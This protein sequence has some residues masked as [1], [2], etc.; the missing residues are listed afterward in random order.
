[1]YRHTLNIMIFIVCYIMLGRGYIIAWTSRVYA[2]H[3]TLPLCEG[4]D[5][6]IRAPD[7]HRYGAWSSPKIQLQLLPPHSTVLLWYSLPLSASNSTSVSFHF[8]IRSQLRRPHS[9]SA[10]SDSFNLRPRPHSL[11]ASTFTFALSFDL[12][13]FRSFF[14]SITISACRGYMTSQL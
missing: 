4:P 9:L 1:M 11:S 2:L 8:H 3:Q 7:C 13:R 5:Y 12:V 14:F 10:S 6:V